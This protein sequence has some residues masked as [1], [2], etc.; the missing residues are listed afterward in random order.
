MPET[1]CILRLNSK[2][3]T[4]GWDT[5]AIHQYY[6]PND[7]TIYSTSLM[8]NSTFT[9]SDGKSEQEISAKAFFLLRDNQSIADH[10]R[11]VFT[12]TIV[13]EVWKIQMLAMHP[14]WYNYFVLADYS[15]PECRPAPTHTP[16]DILENILYIVPSSESSLYSNRRLS[17][18]GY[19][20]A[21]LKG[22]TYWLGK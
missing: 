10:R 4:E 15:L 16:T 19:A 17:D 22:L 5:V 7:V 21:I 1:R 18:V 14:Y 3:D 6:L 8:Q 11:L 2:L 12:K 20:T 13:D 9:I